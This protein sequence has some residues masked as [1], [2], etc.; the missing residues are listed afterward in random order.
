MAHPWDLTVEQFS[1]IRALQQGL[2]APP[3]SDR[4]WTELLALGMVW[5]DESS[6]PAVMRPTALGRNYDAS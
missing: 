1:A 2:P 3:A 5:I 6:D 4:V